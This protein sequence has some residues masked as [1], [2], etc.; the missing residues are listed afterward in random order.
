MENFPITLYE[1]GK[2]KTTVSAYFGREVELLP[3]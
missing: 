1:C 3:G 2:I